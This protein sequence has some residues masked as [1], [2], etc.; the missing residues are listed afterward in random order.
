VRSVSDEPGGWR[1]EVV[2]MSLGFSPSW[3]EDSL[4][5]PRGR[6]EESETW[7]RIRPRGLRFKEDGRGA[8]T[9]SQEDGGWR[10]AVGACIPRGLT[11]SLEDSLVPPEGE[12]GRRPHQRNLSRVGCRCFQGFVCMCGLLIQ[13]SVGGVLAVGGPL[14]KRSGWVV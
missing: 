6:T 2:P 3:L 8:S 1:L 10:L 11:P 12:D 7:R 13:T 14:R 5:L 4:A 9:T